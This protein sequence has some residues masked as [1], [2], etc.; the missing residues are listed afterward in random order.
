MKITE[1]SDPLEGLAFALMSR[2]IVDRSE[3]MRRRF[4]VYTMRDHCKPFNDHPWDH[5]IAAG[6]L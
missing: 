3:W 1:V 6:G 2:W 4:H 5:Q